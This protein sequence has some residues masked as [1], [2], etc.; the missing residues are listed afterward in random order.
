[1][2]EKMKK[3]FV[4][5]YRYKISE[6]V[7]RD[8]VLNGITVYVE[9]NCTHND[10]EESQKRIINR[11]ISR[12]K[13]MPLEVFERFFET[14]VI[15]KEVDVI[16]NTCEMLAVN[17]INNS[18]FITDDKRQQIMEDYF[19]KSSE[20]VNDCCEWSIETTQYIIGLLDFANGKTDCISEEIIEKANYYTA[21]EEY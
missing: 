21:K 6:G 8:A 12:F 2:I 10:D 17:R 4:E 1:M 11:E 14:Y 13:L 7:I 9:N 15:R 16:L 18:I 20:L 5:C 19:L 3:A